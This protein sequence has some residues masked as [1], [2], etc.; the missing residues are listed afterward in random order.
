MPD[1]DATDFVAVFEDSG[2]VQ[3]RQVLVRRSATADDGADGGASRQ[4]LLQVSSA[5]KRCLRRVPDRC[6][7][8][9]RHTRRTVRPML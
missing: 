7:N 8:P 1:L 5:M 2:V 4:K 3:I 6:L 9:F